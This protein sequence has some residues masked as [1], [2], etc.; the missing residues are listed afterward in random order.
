M[1]F[2][3]DSKEDQTILGQWAKAVNVQK[4]RTAQDDRNCPIRTQ[5][6]DFL[7]ASTWTAFK[8]ASTFLGEV[9]SA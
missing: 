6:Y 9:A 4:T 8:S 3:Q 2:R 1:S 7:S 5:L